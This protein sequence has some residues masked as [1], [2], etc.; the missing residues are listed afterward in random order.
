MRYILAS[1]SPRR[2]AL[3]P[4]LGLPFEIEPAAVDES[5]VT[6]AEPAVNVVETALLKATTVASRV[7]EPAIIVAA[8]T[9]VALGKRMLH[10][11][12]NPNDARHML[13]LLSG[14]AHQ[15]HTGLV[16]WHTGSGHYVTDVA[17]IEVLMRPFSDAE[18]ERYVATGDPLDK[19]G[20]YAIQEADFNPVAALDGCYAGV[21]GLP[22]CHLARSLRALGIGASADIATAC[23]AHNSITCP[24][25]ESI[26]PLNPV[27][28]G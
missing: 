3:I 1:A 7:R 18:I 24:V 4:L 14:R 2:R 15:V 26:L 21:I 12:T 13:R 19:A 22:L 8:D 28:R 5:Q 6:H 11:P 20:G 25:F 10:K 17:T 23:Q 16:V 9:T 27:V